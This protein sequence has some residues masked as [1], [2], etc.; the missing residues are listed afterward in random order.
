MIW[1]RNPCSR[2]IKRV[3][4]KPSQADEAI[5]DRNLLE[6]ILISGSWWLPRWQNKYYEYMFVHKRY[7][8]YLNKS[9]WI[10]YKPYSFL[11]AEIR[12]YSSWIFWYDFQNVSAIKWGKRNGPMFSHIMLITASQPRR[13][14]GSK[15]I[16]RQLRL[17]LQ[18]C[19]R[20]TTPSQRC[21]R[22]T[23]MYAASEYLACQHGQVWLASLISSKYNPILSA[24]DDD[25][26]IKWFDLFNDFSYLRTK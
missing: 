13:E 16:C 19:R 22:E 3:S 4:N 10:T 21:R 8:C 11:P 15:V 7:S 1:H 20:Y 12:F 26:E 23:D 14:Y 9:C 18:P 24:Y 17:Q 2:L 25:Q 5:S 6:E